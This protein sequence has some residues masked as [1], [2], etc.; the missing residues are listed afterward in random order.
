ME[1]EF[2]PFMEPTAFPEFIESSG[3]EPFIEPEPFSVIKEHVDWK[4]F[5]KRELLE[6]DAHPTAVTD[7]EAR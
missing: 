3:W 1:T 5:K 7:A 4:E 6:P 2:E